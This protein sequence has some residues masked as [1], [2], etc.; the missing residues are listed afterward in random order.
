MLYQSND[1]Y[2]AIPAASP[3]HATRTISQG[4]G[5]Q[6]VNVPAPDQV[7]VPGSIMLPLAPG[8]G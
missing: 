4:G 3:R 7:E 1:C 6:R 5:I 2:R 8:G